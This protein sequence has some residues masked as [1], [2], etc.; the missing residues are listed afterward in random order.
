MTAI[1][2]TANAKERDDEG[3]TVE[4]HS[5]T[6]MY[7]FGENLKEA[8]KLFT[9]EVVFAHY[10]QN[11]VVALQS[12]LRASALAGDDAATTAVKAAEWAPTISAPRKTKIE[13]VKEEAANMSRED[14]QALIDAL[15][16]AA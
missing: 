16:E 6:V 5:R 15:M 9:D 3:Q 1:E 8:V 10:K 11:A 13:R 14:R 12:V 2:V 7:D 4:E